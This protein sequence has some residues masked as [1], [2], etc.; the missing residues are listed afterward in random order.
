MLAANLNSRWTLVLALTVGMLLSTGK[1]HAVPAYVRQTGQEC[2]ACHVSF[3]ELT[4][5]EMKALAAY[6]ES[7]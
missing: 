1:A 7:L 5:N 2:I 3:P 6:L 4:P